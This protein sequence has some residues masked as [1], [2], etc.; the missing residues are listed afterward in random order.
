M[1]IKNSK[2]R[3][4]KGKFLRPFKDWILDRKLKKQTE[5]KSKICME[6]DWG[7]G[8]NYGCEM[9]YR[10]DEKGGIYILRTRF[11]KGKVKK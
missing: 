1:K 9:L 7:F 10:V 4:I 2:L 3:I 6:I 8:G 11:F 5:V